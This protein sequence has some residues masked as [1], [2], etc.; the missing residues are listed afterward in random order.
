MRIV[1]QTVLHK[2]QRYPTAGDWQFSE[3]DRVLTIAVSDTGD[4]RSNMLVAIHELVEAICCAA[5]GID[6][7]EVD[8]FDMAHPEL[9]EPGAHPDAPYHDQH[10]LA[11]GIERIL[12]NALGISWCE[13]EANIAGLDE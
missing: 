2:A 1:I 7:A 3:S 10:S 9:D 5:A 8:A 6:Q 12:G 4:W 11:E 13:H